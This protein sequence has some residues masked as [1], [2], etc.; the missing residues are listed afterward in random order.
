MDGPNVNFKLFDTLS[1]DLEEDT[2]CKLLNIGSCGLH[3]MHNAFKAGSNITTWD[4]EHTLN[5]LGFLKIPQPDVM[6]SPKQQVQL[7]PF[8]VLST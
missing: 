6:I 1:R 7:F 4:I 8:E 3:I 5:C 2:G